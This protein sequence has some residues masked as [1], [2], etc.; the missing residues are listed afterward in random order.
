MKMN[1]PKLD[2]RFILDVNIVDGTMVAP[3]TPFTKI[4]RMHNNGS[5]VWPKGTQLVWIGGDKLTDAI[6]VEVEVCISIVVINFQ[7]LLQFE[8]LK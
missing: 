2:S 5:I 7:V 6:S 1:R 3:S 4:W 8:V